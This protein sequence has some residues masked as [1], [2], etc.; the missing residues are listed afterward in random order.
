MSMAARNTDI[1]TMSTKVDKKNISATNE[2]NAV[3]Q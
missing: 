3:W 1:L 2:E